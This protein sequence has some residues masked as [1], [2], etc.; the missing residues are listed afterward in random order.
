V[1]EVLRK[2]V[3]LQF[4]KEFWPAQIKLFERELGLKM[5]K[6]RRRQIESRYQCYQ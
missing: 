1:E 5:K 3:N 4:L 2:L 6:R